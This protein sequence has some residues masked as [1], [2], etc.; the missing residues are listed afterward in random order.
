MAFVNI[1]EV[2]VILR[3]RMQRDRCP[4][5]KSSKVTAKSDCEMSQV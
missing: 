5:I 3:G 4:A 1:N 2:P